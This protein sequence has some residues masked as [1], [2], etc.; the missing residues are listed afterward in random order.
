VSTEAAGEEEEGSLEHQRKAL[1]EGVERPFLQPVAFALPVPAALD[2][3]AARIAQV[4]VHPLLPQH[5]DERGEKG[6]QQTCIHETGDSDDLA[7]WVFL[8]RW[9]G[10]SLT[11]DGGLIES[12]EDGTEEGGG[13]LVGIG[14]EVRVD[15]DDKRRADGG[16][17]TR[18][19]E[20]VR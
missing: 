8:N 13:L 7:R 14:L 2:H 5:G 18:L 17:Q 6:D 10:R 20:Q 15:I 11:G 1:D 12:E 16:E 4:P 19:W 3:R 9:D